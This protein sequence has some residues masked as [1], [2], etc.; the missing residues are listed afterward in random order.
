MQSHLS[1][2]GNIFFVVQQHGAFVG[3][4]SSAAV[5]SGADNG[6]WSASQLGLDVTL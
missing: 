2:Q 3:I 4:N 5:H 6:Q 1:K